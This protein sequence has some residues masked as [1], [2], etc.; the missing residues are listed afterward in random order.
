MRFVVYGVG[1]IGG[2]I[3][4]RLSLTGEAV[5]GIARGAQLE[6]LR[7]HGLRVETP[8]GVEETHFPVASRPAEVAFAADDVILLCMKTQDTAGAL[9]ELRD[10]GVGDQP[11]VCVQ[12]AVENERLALRIFPNV[13]SV[14]IML[15]SVFLEPGTIRNHSHPRAGV[16]DIGRYPRGTDDVS[17]TIAAVFEKAGF[18]SRADP[19]VMRVKYGKLLLNLA[20][21]LQAAIGAGAYG[22]PAFAAARKEGAA[23]LTAAGI[24][25][26]ELSADDPRA[27]LVQAAPVG[28]VGH[29][30]GSSWQSLAR[31]APSIE[32]DYLNGE[33]SLLGRI[34]G[35]PTP[36]N[37]R[38][39]R[40]GQE[41]LR[42]RI[43]VE[44]I[45]NAAL[46]RELG[47]AP[48]S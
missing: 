34:H 27:A 45:D 13:Y 29:V 24:G 19:D 21:I 43:T 33:I 17:K 14:C 25:W 39:M 41:M 1:A 42:E 3:A 44:S 31:G 22:V 10:A 18:L 23:V 6:A 48:Q 4:S 9:A 28:G 47:L 30:G 16:L 37:D 38:L 8:D 36:V 11:I 35:V 7:Q 15:P 40:L 20:N 2:V 12:N 46:E 26:T 5:L 32:T